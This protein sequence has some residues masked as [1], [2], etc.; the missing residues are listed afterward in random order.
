[1]KAK[2]PTLPGVV[3]VATALTISVLATPVL[4]SATGADADTPSSTGRTQAPRDT[5]AA[6]D[7]SITTTVKATLATT[8][9][10]EADRISVKTIDGVVHLEGM[11]RNESQRALALQTAKNVRGVTAVSDELR[12]TSKA[13]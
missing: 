6:S 7:N 3:V 2:V 1:M 8:K 13:P 12:A 5:A 10:L 4:V 9:G 11:V